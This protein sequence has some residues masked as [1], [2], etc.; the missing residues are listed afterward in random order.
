MPEQWTNSGL[1]GVPLRDA[2]ARLGM[3][4]DALWMRIRRGGLQAYK[5]DGKW[6]VHLPE[7][8]AEHAQEPEQWGEPF[9]ERDQPAA[10]NAVREIID[11]Q[12]R[13][14]AFLRSEVEA[15]R[16]S[17]G[18]FRVMLA[19][20]SA[21]I[22]ELAGRLQALTSGTD[23]SQADPAERAESARQSRENPRNRTLDTSITSLCQKQRQARR[24]LVRRHH[25]RRLGS[26]NNLINNLGNNRILWRQ[27]HPLV[28]A[29]IPVRVQLARINPL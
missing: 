21:E 5:I 15:G 11:R 10:I 25:R 17:E 2:A 8:E 13:E 23:R 22:T 26:V 7:R 18:E 20:Q 6:F 16:Q 3:T 29:I 27:D 1:N 24:Q 12:D 14:I 28:A 4:V 9:T 19:R